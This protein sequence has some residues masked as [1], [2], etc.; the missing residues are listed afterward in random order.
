MERQYRKEVIIARSLS[1]VTGILTSSIAPFAQRPGNGEV[2]FVQLKP[3][4]GHTCNASTNC[5]LP[6]GEGLL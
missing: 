1:V 2:G 6:N 3:E 4:H 5:Y